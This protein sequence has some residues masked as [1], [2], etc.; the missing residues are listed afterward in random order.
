[1]PEE[2]L[3]PDAHPPANAEYNALIVQLVRDQIP[4]RQPSR[5]E[6]GQ[7]VAAV[8]GSVQAPGLLAEVLPW[9]AG[10]LQATTDFRLPAAALLAALREDLLQ[11]V[12]DTY[13]AEEEAAHA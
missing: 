11:Y 5:I 4:A 1:V 6:I 12:A 7:A 8:L 2:T 10:F 3:A 13:D 9:W